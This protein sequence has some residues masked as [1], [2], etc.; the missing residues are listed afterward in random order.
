MGRLFI[1]VTLA[2][3]AVILLLFCPIVIETNVHYDMN[4]KKFGFC[5]FLYGFIKLLGGYAATYRGG[6]ALHVSPQKA[7]LIPYSQMD[8]ERKRFSFVRTFRLISLILTTETGA[9][10]LLP[11][12]IA[13][14]FLRAYFFIIG[15]DKEKIENNLWLTDGDVLRI[16]LNCVIYFNLFILVKNLIM[17]LKEKI[18]ILWN[19]KIKKSTA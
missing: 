17:F 14:T 8:S 7:I 18:K 11:V 19:R 12:S 6:I 15:G 16:S 2:L 5:V 3:I 1:Y 13:H 9:E 4:R 10:Y